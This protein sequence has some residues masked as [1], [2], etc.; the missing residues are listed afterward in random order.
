[1][2]EGILIYLMR[3]ANIEKVAAFLTAVGTIVALW[4]QVPKKEKLTGTFWFESDFSRI[5]LTIKNIG[6]TDAYF[7]ATKGALTEQDEQGYYLT[8]NS[9]QETYFISRYSPRHLSIKTPPTSKSLKI[10]KSGQE[11]KLSIFTTNGTPIKLSNR[12]TY[13]KDEDK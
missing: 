10:V 12:K 3:V 8:L 6:K 2:E 4:K 11:Y 9:D 1:M 13:F 5:H 7:D